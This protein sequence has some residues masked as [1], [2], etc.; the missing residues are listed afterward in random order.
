MEKIYV[1]EENNNKRK[2]FKELMGSKVPNHLSV[3]M[4]L[5]AFASFVAMQF[6]GNSSYAIMYDDVPERLTTITAGDSKYRD[7]AGDVSADN[8]GVPYMLTVPGEGQSEMQVFCLDKDKPFPTTAGQAVTYDRTPEEVN[9][10]IV[11]I[12]SKLDD[13][14]DT[15]GKQ[16][17]EYT[18]TW[19]T[20]TA[21]WL[22]N[23]QVSEDV[24]KDDQTIAAY[25]ISGASRI[26]DKEENVSQLYNNVIKPLV[27]KAGTVNK[28][29]INITKTGE[30]T[31][32]S[33]NK[34]YKSPLIT[35][36]G[37]TSG[38][39]YSLT[40]N[41]VP[42]G[43]K[44]YREDG[45]EIKDINNIDV[46]KFYVLVP[47]DKVT[48]K[49]KKVT[50]SVTGPAPVAYVYEPPEGSGYQKVTVLEKQNVST[51]LDLEYTPVVPDTG[52]NTA[53]SIYFIGLVVLL[54]GLGIIYA[55]TKSKVIEE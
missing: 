48:E 44:L 49:T 9:A 41:N 47:I 38:G 34:Y 30:V 11:Y 54:C 52:L 40:M 31:V 42:D 45:T 29:T 1:E 26:K 5:V 15:T 24:V 39:S 16:L 12:M 27:D 18:R 25:K 46:T 20:Q 32:T 3:L 50:L 10:G 22:Y 21:I 37:F 36:T 17:N 43:T 33:D 55:N 7:I 28:N 2:S 35:V 51:G 4:I 14:Y 8:Y 6:S 53:Q 13:Y 19:I 23:N